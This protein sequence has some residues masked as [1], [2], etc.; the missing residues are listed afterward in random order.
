MFQELFFSVCFSPHWPYFCFLWRSLPCFFSFFQ[1]LCFADTVV[2]CLIKLWVKGNVRQTEK[3][4]PPTSGRGCL[5]VCA[6]TEGQPCLQMDR[7]VVRGSSRCL[8]WPLLLPFI[9][10]LA[11]TQRQ[12]QART[13]KTLSYAL[14]PEVSRSPPSIQ[15]LRCI[16]DGGGLDRS[17]LGV[18]FLLVS[19]MNG[20]VKRHYLIE[21]WLVLLGSCCFRWDGS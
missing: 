2:P 7:W 10:P 3:P 6:W 17:N 18:Q 4:F 14:M 16:P 13:L 1:L 15:F 11:S 12:G 19:L 9:E 5:L 20:V 8:K 21:R